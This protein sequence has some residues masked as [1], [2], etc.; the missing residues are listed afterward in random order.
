MSMHI[1][2]LIAVAA[3]LATAPPAAPAHAD[4]ARTF[5]SGL[6]NDQGG[7]NTDCFRA[8]PCRT[9]KQAHDHTLDNGE[10]TVLDPGSY[11]AVTIGKNISIINDG[12]GEAGILV[13]GGGTGITI[14]APG[15]AAVT[16]RGITI[17]GIGFGGGNGLVFLAGASLNVENCTVR[18]LDGTNL[19]NGIIFAPGTGTS[20]LQITNTVVTDNSANGILIQQ[21]GPTNVNA[22]IEHVGL[23]HNGGTGLILDSKVAGGIVSTMV[24]DS[25]ASNNGGSGVGGGFLAQAGPGAA[26]VQL[27]LNRSFAV[28][29]PNH[30][31]AGL[32]QGIVRIWVS[33]SVIWRNAS[34][35]FT[36]PGAAIITYANN[37]VSGNGSNEGS[38]FPDSLK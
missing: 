15:T 25:V 38:Q 10:I 26:P 29:N 8:T 31:V 19:G 7:A 21:S 18:N 37:V 35:W 33:Q 12:M 16:L 11:G 17:K 2:S 30:G 23:Y 32:G 27:F 1:P 36:D 9:F 4:Q 3:L 5:V 13:S 28:T 14:N 22:V 24:I 34:G 20:G 6:G